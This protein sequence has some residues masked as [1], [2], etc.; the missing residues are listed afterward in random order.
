LPTKHHRI[1]A[2]LPI[3]SEY[4]ARL[5]EGALEF[6][7]E[8]ARI[9]L[10]DVFY[11]IDE[12]NRLRLRD[13]LEYDAAM[14]WAS[15]DAGWVEFLLERD[16]PVIGVSGDWPVE[17]VPC[18]AF[19]TPMVVESAVDHLVTRGASSILYLDFRISGLPG[20]EGR[21][22]LFREA[23]GCRGISASSAEVFGADREGESEHQR[24]M[25]LVGRPARRVQ[26]ALR[27]LPK[28]IGV[29][30]GEDHLARH[31]CE[32]AGD[33]GLR[34][35]EDLMVLG[36]GDFRTAECGHPQISSLPL[37]GEL[38]GGQAFATLDRM[39]SE[40]VTPKPFTPVI[41]PPV[42]G[43]E[44]TLGTSSDD[45]I[46]RARSIIEA[47]C[48]EG[49][50]VKEVAAGVGVSPQT[51]HARFVKR[52]SRS[53]GAEIR[54]NRLAAAKRF[55]LNSGITITRVSHLCGFS[56]QNRFSNFFQRE[57]GMSPR[58]WRNAHGSDRSR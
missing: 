56:Q 47:R 38:V 53:P 31:V 15:R 8:Q 18:I 4:S 6:A 36:F 54:R 26:E 52:Y 11:P 29:W 33:L 1:A 27:K 51:L 58:T 22:R 40:G 13:P 55:L 10:V 41:P 20:R 7:R 44:S 43:R 42:V 2:I 12:P 23:A 46:G 34:I 48:C 25:P 32:I 16:I 24:R 57:T 37:P 14:I 5:L 17:L 45:A 28:P 50:T 9:I 30:C 21:V 35:P 19:D 39:L 3:E 49:L